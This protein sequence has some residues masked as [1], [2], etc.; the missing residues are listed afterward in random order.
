MS[1]FYDY[2]SFWNYLND[3]LNERFNGSYEYKFYLEPFLEGCFE[4]DYSTVG[5]FSDEGL[6]IFFKLDEKLPGRFREEEF[7]QSKLTVTVNPNF[8]IK[9][10]ELEFLLIKYSQLLRKK[11]QQLRENKT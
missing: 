4:T 11:K 10:K 1:S 9:E 7:L 3:F 6:F 8:Y 2:N 5:I